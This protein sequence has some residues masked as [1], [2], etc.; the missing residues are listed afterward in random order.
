MRH[1]QV[2]VR[3]GTRSG[4]PI[5]VAVHSRALGPAVGGVRMRRYAD[6]RDGVEDA[7]RL[8]EA[9]TY[10]TAA[11]GLPFGGA[12]SVIALGPDTEPTPRLRQAALEDLG[13][14]IEELGGGY[15]AGPD[16]GTGPADMAVL[17]TR[18]TH[19][20][21][22][23]EEQ[24]GTGSSSGPTAA[25]VV[26]AL[27]AAARA[28]LGT[29]SLTGRTVL[30]SGY[31]SVG[32]LVARALTDARVLVSD[33][34]P[35]KQ[36]EAGQDGH[37]WIRPEDVLKTRCDIFVPAAVGGILTPDTVPGLACRLI[38]GPANNQLTDDSVADLLA[39]RGI[40][41]VPD[42]VASAGG[43]IYITS[44]DLL[45]LSHEDAYARVTALGATV[46]SLLAEPRPPLRAA[47]SLAEVRLTGAE[48]TNEHLMAI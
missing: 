35:A 11:A 16:V 3:R 37:G 48:R 7:L 27:R 45:G 4:L 23:P 14:L 1:E 26:A 20:V 46:G 43:V 19:V 15:T 36:E 41:Y 9:M 22:L 42:F 39:A 30:I 47:L 2:T 18:T 34:D 25:G 33:I 38:V 31:G 32:A 12:K 29:E 6:W 21:C 17:R 8:S 44:R 13:D 5:A 28:V 40:T 10:K 24:G